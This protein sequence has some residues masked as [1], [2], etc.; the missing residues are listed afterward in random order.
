MDTSNNLDSLQWVKSSASAAG[1]CPEGTR[2]QV[3]ACL[4]P[5]GGR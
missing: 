5:H 4:S 2:R 1:A 3:R